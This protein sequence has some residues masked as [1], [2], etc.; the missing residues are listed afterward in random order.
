M[1]R[2]ALVFAFG[3]LGLNIMSAQSQIERAKIYVAL[4]GNNVSAISAQL[5]SLAKIKGSPSQAFTGALEMRKAGLL[6]LP[7]DRL[8]LFKLGNR[9]LEAEI[10]D[11]VENAEFRFLRL[12]IQEQAPA[13]LGYKD[14]LEKDKD[15]LRSHY[16]NLPS[17]TIQ[18]ILNY[19][20]QSKILKTSYFQEG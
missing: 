4:S 13:I 20:T 9:K 11:D 7:I 2:I 8:K 3:L 17:A 14:D 12:I 15:Y 16:K 18:A 5:A 10:K 6:K 1:R 19:C